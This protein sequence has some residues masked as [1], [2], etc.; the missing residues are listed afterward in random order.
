MRREKGVQERSRTTTAFTRNVVRTRVLSTAAGIKLKRERA[1]TSPTK[2]RRKK[3]VSV[4]L[5]AEGIHA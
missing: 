2:I 4:D 1:A 3:E 5:E